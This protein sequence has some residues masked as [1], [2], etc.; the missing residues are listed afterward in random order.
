LNIRLL[1]FHE[2]SMPLNE[3]SG[4]SFTMLIEENPKFLQNLRHKINTYK[5]HF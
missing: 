4:A 3:I 5:E 1:S 2:L